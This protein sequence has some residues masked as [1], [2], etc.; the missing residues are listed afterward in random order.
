MP[1]IREFLIFDRGSP[2]FDLGRVSTCCDGRVHSVDSGR[3]SGLRSSTVLGPRNHE[4]DRLRD[5]DVA[6]GSSGLLLSS[7]Y[8]LELRE[9]QL[10]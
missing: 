3:V 5:L 1:R 6:N 9:K 2:L 4:S 8:G 10:F 7:F